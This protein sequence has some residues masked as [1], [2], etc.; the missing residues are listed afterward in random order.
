MNYMLPKDME[1]YL[2]YYGMHFNNALCEFAVSQMKR[3]DKT[4]GVLKEITPMKME[5]LKSLLAKHKVEIEPN[6]IYDALFLANM[7]KA[8]YFGSSIEDEAHLAKY[9]EDVL[10]DPDGYE[11]VALAR[12]LADCSA[13]GVSIYWDMMI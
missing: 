6:G 11:G 3:E 9:I 8:D 2:S 12:Y 4:T 7:A 1:L 13:K 5:E 10:C